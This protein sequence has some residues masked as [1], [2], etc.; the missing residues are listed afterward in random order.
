MGV[1]IVR[2]WVFPSNSACVAAVITTSSV[3]GVLVDDRVTFTTCCT[4]VRMSV[5]S[6][7]MYHVVISGLCDS[8]SG[9]CVCTSS[10]VN[11]SEYC[12]TD[13]APCEIFCIVAT[14]CALL[15]R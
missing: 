12:R 13:S 10:S 4:T 9:N 6:P 8:S 2:G 3:T 1:S 14:A 11:L 7:L 5:R 15:S